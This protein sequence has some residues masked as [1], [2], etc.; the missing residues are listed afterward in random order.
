MATNRRESLR[1]QPD[2]SREGS[3]PGSRTRDTGPKIPDVVRPTRTPDTA[4]DAAA[5]AAAREQARMSAEAS[6]TESGEL[7][8]ISIVD[9]AD[10]PEGKLIFLKDYAKR[11]GSYSAEKGK[12]GVSVA[13]GSAAALT[14]VGAKTV[15]FGVRSILYGMDW[16]GRGLDKIGN[17][18]IDKN[19]PLLKYVLNPLVSLLDS[20]AK[21]LGLDKS[22]YQ[23]IKANKEARKKLVDKLHK[24]FLANEKKYYKGL[25]AAAKKTKRQTVLKEKF[26]DDVAKLLGEELDDAAKKDEPA[27]PAEPT[28]AAA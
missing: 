7:T 6:G 27:A 4:M 18:L 14:Y 28:A 16:L 8:E 21:F 25:D 22:L 23:Y 24:E 15:G 3:A 26:G 20:S 13:V 10:A 1:R 19:I 12:T 11:A 17:K 5:I 2:T 9:L